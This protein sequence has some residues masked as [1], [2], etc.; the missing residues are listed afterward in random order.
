MDSKPS[1]SSM[2]QISVQNELELCQTDLKRADEVNAKL[3]AEHSHNNDTLE[4]L[5]KSKQ[6]IEKK[7]QGLLEENKELGVQASRSSHMEETI[8]SLELDKNECL[9]RI[10]V[11]TEQMVAKESY[12]E[13][14]MAGMERD[15][16]VRYD[17]LDS[18]RDEELGKVKERYIKLF[19]EKA[20]E[21]V[22]I[23]DEH[24][25]CKDK[26]KE[27]DRK[28]ADLQYREEEL[29]NLLSKTQSSIEEKYKGCSEEVLLEIEAMKSHTGNE[30]HQKYI[31]F[32]VIV[33]CCN[34]DSLCC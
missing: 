22:M 8:R 7:V 4:V 31:I 15:L 24:S 9:E 3:T 19:Q 11:M 17:E 26:L 5:R 27:R 16:Q 23:R 13:S 1:S 21:C 34:S 33:K 18:N 30:M 12:Y 20:E 28:I 25:H 32:L 14:K 2:L 6:S 29:Q 10:S